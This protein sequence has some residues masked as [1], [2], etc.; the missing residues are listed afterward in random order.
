[1]KKKNSK[2]SRCGSRSW[3]HSVCYLPYDYSA[4]DVASAHTMQLH[5]GKHH[6]T[7]V[8]PR[9]QRS[10][11]G[12]G[13]ADFT[14]QLALQPALKVSGGGEYVP[15][16]P[17]GIVEMTMT[18][19]NELCDNALPVLRNA[20]SKVSAYKMG[21]KLN[22][23]C[24][25]GF[26]RKNSLMHC[27]G[28]FSHPS[29]TNK[30]QCGSTSSKH[31]EKQVTPNPEQQKERKTTEMQS[32]TQLTDQVN[33]PGYCGEPPPWEHED[34]KRIY[35]FVVGQTV[36]YHCVQGFRAILRGQAKSVCMESQGK[37]RWTQ[38]KLTCTI[39]RNN[40]L[41]PG[42]EESQVSTDDPLGTTDATS[43]TD[44][45][46]Q[47]EVAATM[48]TF[49]YTT[50][51]GTDNTEYQLTVAGYVL[52]LLIILLLSGA[53]WQWRWRKSRRTI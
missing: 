33:T 5:C 11:G 13:Q 29:W 4:L 19:H 39:E 18:N 45:Q 12:A 20:I 24:K 31:T 7:R 37:A 26:R 40:S 10:P 46:K 32:Q 35:H 48:E 17:K 53:T 23:Q 36:D 3:Q 2:G 42:D 9:T 15:F 30:C 25:R 41:V 52:L 16:G 8:D 22:C 27:G 28:N 6:P 14:T 43:M 49:I 38:P 1:M 34:S 47:T 51:Y 44:F 21:T 50:E